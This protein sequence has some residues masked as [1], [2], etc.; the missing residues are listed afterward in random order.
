MLKLYHCSLICPLCSV[1]SQV[2]ISALHFHIPIW[3]VL[4]VCLPVCLYI[5]SKSQYRHSNWGSVSSALTVLC[6]VCLPGLM[7][8]VKATPLGCPTRLAWD[9]FLL[10]SVIHLTGS[11]PK[12]LHVCPIG[13]RNC[14]RITLHYHD[15]STQL[16]T[17]VQLFTMVSWGT[18]KE[19]GST[20]E[21]E[22]CK[23]HVNKQ[24]W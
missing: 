13:L 2:E 8:R 23:W 15:V 7:S 5:H 1:N 16:S 4:P 6:V 12:E 24:F 9:W 18:P 17:W 20:T 14:C 21:G 19:D 10:G 11:W 3:C 22:I